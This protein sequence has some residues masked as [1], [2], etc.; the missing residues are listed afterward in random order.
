MKTLMCSTL[1]VLTCLLL[2]ARPKEKGPVP[3]YNQ[4]GQLLHPADYREWMFLSA[5]WPG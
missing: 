4:K 1:V 5:G 3:Q 2:S